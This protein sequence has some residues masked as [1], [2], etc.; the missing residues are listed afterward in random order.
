MTTHPLGRLSGSLLAALLAVTAAAGC[1]ETP[2][3]GS[4]GGGGDVGTV[5]PSPLCGN[6]G[7]PGLDD[8]RAPEV[9]GAIFSP[10][11]PQFG[12][13]VAATVPAARDQRRHAPHPL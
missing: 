2:P 13:T 1:S 5:P 12:S 9:G 11:Q 4:T 10:F 8:P 7:Q 3:T 6:Q